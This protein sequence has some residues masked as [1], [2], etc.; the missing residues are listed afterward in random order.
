MESI[1]EYL[2]KLTSDAIIQLN[3]QEDLKNFRDNYGD[4]NFVVVL[5]KDEKKK[6]L[7]TAFFQCVERL[8]N[9]PFKPTFYFGLIDKKN[10]SYK[11]FENKNESKDQQ[12]YP[13]I[14]SVK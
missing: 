1:L 10:Y 12:N 4:M 5:N 7:E 8:A 6:Y 13:D 2:N 11:Q 14:V 9:G 3:N